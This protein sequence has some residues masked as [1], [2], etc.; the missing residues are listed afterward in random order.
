MHLAH[1]QPAIFRY[2]HKVREAFN[3]NDLG[4]AYYETLE[5]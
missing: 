4:D 1:P 3:P 5:D 2:Q